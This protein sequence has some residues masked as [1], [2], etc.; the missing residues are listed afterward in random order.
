MA[1]RDFVGILKGGHDRVG[2][3]QGSP[4]ELICDTIHGLAKDDYSQIPRLGQTQAGN[5]FVDW[6]SIR[7]S[8]PAYGV[9]GSGRIADKHVSDQ[10]PGRGNGPSFD[11]TF[12]QSKSIPH[13]MIHTLNQV[14]FR[15]GYAEI[16]P[17]P[18]SVA[19]GTALFILAMVISC[20]RMPAGFSQDKP[21]AMTPVVQMLPADTQAVFSLPDSE[22]F[23]NSW[24]KTQLGMLAADN[25]L[26]PFWNAQRQE[27][28]NRF[29]EAGWQLSLEIDDLSDISGGQAALAWIAR[30]KNEAKPFS[31][32]MIID[33]AGRVAPTEN[34]LKRID[35]Q[36]KAKNAVAKTSDVNGIKVM[37]YTIPKAVGDLRIRESFYALSKEQ[38]LACDD[39]A[40]M[41]ELLAAQSGGKTD[42]LAKTDVYQAVQKKIDTEGQPPEVEYFVRPIGF[43]KLLRSISTKASNNKE[44]ILKILEKEGF[45]NI[46]C[47]AGNIQ[48]HED[49]F[50]FF[51]NG[52]VLL[53]KPT[54][55]SVKIL[56]FPNL[57]TL[58]PPDFINRD[59]A[60][61][62]SFSW[63]L[64]NAFPRFKG[65]VDAYVGPDTFSA[66]MDGIRD[67]PTGP[68]IDVYKDV[69]PYISTQFFVVTEIK[70]PIGPESKRSLVLLKLNDTGQKLA[71]VIERF[72]KNE[73]NSQREDV[74]GVRVWKFKNESEEE[75]VTDFGSKDDNK[76][77]DEEEHLLDQWAMSIL[78]DY[79]LFAADA[80]MIKDTIRAAKSGSQGGQFA[81]EPD[82]AR[83]HE[84]LTVVTGGQPHSF[85]DI[86]R[87]DRAFEMQYEL[88]RQGTITQSKSMLASILEKILKPKNP[89]AQQKLN[90][91]NLPPFGQIR[92][93]FTPSAGTVRTDED[94]WALQSFILGK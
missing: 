36:L 65:I 86:T 32:A 21:A 34:L 61:V 75:L 59:A 14:K 27:I 1:N 33:V 69:L 15:I 70:Q 6:D 42:S 66:V 54:S 94:G 89:Q 44:D 73:P 52:F 83:T 29:Q 20:A 47:V 82:V 68:Q 4:D 8:I 49:S 39:L 30:P 55:E 24:S 12:T 51:H 62:L 9:Q 45:E 17:V 58:V 93:Y 10:R 3:K 46:Q 92:G 88:F 31:L 57:P 2:A 38:L 25:L 7:S 64:K 16:R 79:F 63:D 77:A 35:G 11:S 28:Q 60:S 72:G 22:R 13:R 50:D 5:S 74:E 26:K 40:T 41:T 76:A 80:E 67:D 85:T 56:D 78:D 23:L 18:R 37:Q 87:S 84:T 53:K 90:G 81:K 19:T 43:A 48:I 91:A 71:K